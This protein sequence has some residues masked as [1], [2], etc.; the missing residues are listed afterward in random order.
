MRS[1]E[2]TG[3]R[4]PPHDAWRKALCGLLAALALVQVAGCTR[5]LWVQRASA[6][7]RYT[8]P[9][10]G[11]GDFQGSFSPRLR[12]ASDGLQS[13]YSGTVAV[14]SVDR[15]T[16][17]QML[18]PGLFLATPQP[19][20]WGG[21]RHPVVHL[22]GEQRAPSTLVL[23]TVNP[24]PGAAGYDEMILFVPFVVKA[25]GTLWHNYVVR[26]YLNH[27]IP[28]FGGNELYGYAKVTARLDQSQQGAVVRHTVVSEDL[29]TTWF[30]DDI[31]PP[32]AAAT[33]LAA[34]GPPRWDEVRKILEMP[35]LG[36]R[37]DG[38]LVCSY[39]ELDYSGATIATTVSRHQVV[40]S[41]RPGMEPWETMGTL[42]SA[43]NGAF[44]I[45]RARWRLAWPWLVQG[46]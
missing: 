33:G 37:P 9:Y 36:T 23:G 3:V 20:L 13:T 39:W 8:P 30:R 26:M 7:F 1:T 6:Y 15:A 22:I 41:F 43:D 17:Q 10:L 4:L 5:P 42:R 29:A 34:T 38:V 11:P 44:A 46:C 27:I 32:A 21:N 24:V 31:D 40:T 16:V 35:F 28:V 14:T 12:E 18:P 2:G 45:S 19:N 25:N